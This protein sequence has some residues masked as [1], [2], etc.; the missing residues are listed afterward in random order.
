[1]DE[2]GGEQALGALE[3]DDSARLAPDQGD[4]ALGARQGTEHSALVGGLK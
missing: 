1:V 2:L 3:A 4:L